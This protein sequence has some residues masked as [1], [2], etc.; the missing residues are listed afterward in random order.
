MAQPAQTIMKALPPLLGLPVLYVA[1]LC[2]LVLSIAVVQYGSWW[3][4]MTL[5]GAECAA[6][7]WLE[8]RKGRRKR[9]RH[10]NPP[11]RF[12]PDLWGKN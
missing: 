12:N 2:T 3:E 4:Q 5:A 6:L 10:R 8:T 9:T 7:A 11:A 1:C